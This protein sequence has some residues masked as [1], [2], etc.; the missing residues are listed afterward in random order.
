MGKD[1]DRY[2]RFDCNYCGK[3]F[4]SDNYKRY[5]IVCKKRIEEI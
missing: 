1:C 3:D 4:R 5:E 2:C